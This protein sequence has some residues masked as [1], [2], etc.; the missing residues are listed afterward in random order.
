PRRRPGPWV[1]AAGRPRDVEED[2]GGR[3]RRLAAG[4]PPRRTGR[5]AAPPRRPQ[6]TPGRQRPD[7]HRIGPERLLRP[8][9]SPHPDE[10]AIIHTGN[11]DIH[12]HHPTLITP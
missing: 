7:R 11:P 12:R 5:T 8:L 3:R 4:V 10:H 1:M 6:P 2:R 9:P